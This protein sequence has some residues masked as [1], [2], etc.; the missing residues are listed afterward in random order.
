MNSLQEDNVK[1]LA[2][3]VEG[4]EYAMLTTTTD[5]GSL[6]S[7]PMATANREFD[8]RLWFFTDIN[9]AK[10]FEV[11]REQHVNV[12]Y[13]DPSKNRYVS[14]SGVAT[15][16]R[17]RNKIEELWMPSAKAWFPEGPNDPKVAL[18]RVDV[19]QAEYW[20]APHGKLVSLVGFVTAMV[21]GKPPH[22]IDE[23]AKVKMA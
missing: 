19:D 23:H 8:G 16:T 14:I 1:K 2:K 20:D 21:T 22:G 6:R 3:L 18:L 13:A 9:A 4:I 7:R 5:N 10:V 15:V 12:S 17:D 11:N